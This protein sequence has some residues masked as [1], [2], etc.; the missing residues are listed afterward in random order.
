M[1]DTRLKLLKTSARIFA[2]K[3]YSAT[4]VRDIVSA[5]R[6]NVS[7]ITYHFG[8]KRGLFFE[9]T[10]YLI[11]QHRQRIWE[12]P[13]R[14]PTPQQIA[15][16][17][18]NQALDLLHQMLDN[19]LDNSLSRKS[20]PL[21]RI[22]AQVEL[23]SVTMRK[24]LCE[25]MAPFRELAYKLLSKLTNLAENSPELLCVAHSIFG[26]IWLSESHRLVLEHQ[27]GITPNYTPTLRQK[28]KQTM[29]AH[30]LAVLN[31]YKKGSKTK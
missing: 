23:E 17:S 6:V 15:E 12:N 9:T 8:G 19:L 31:L 26:Q 28:I 14:I 4:S 24:M 21:E 5:A 11:E 27:L 1:K 22:F 20:V 25:Y 2:R 7:A 30:T 10:H 16:Y 18:Q 3:G 13:S 29:W